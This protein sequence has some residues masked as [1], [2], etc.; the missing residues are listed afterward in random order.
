M[1]GVG[2]PGCFNFS[3][4][5]LEQ[6]LTWG[7]WLQEACCGTHFA[8]C[9]GFSA[10]LSQENKNQ[11]YGIALA[12]AL[13]LSLLFCFLLRFQNIQGGKHETDDA[14]HGGICSHTIGLL[15]Y[16]EVEVP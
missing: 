3:R 16:Q 5:L 1:E 6:E 4:G 12:L 7:V 14:P 10:F 13:L 11:R 9:Y 15:I 2:A 8:P